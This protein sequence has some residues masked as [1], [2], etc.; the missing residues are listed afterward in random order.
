MKKRGGE[1]F[2]NAM[3]IFKS[4]EFKYRISHFPQQKYLNHKMSC[5]WILTPAKLTFAVVYPPINRAGT[6]LEQ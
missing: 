3:L 1:E 2:L 5:L 4:L 6:C